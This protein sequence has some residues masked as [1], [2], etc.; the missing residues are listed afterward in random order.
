MPTELRCYPKLKPSWL[1]GRWVVT[2]QRILLFSFQSP[3]PEWPET[4]CPVGQTEMRYFAGRSLGMDNRQLLCRTMLSDQGNAFSRGRGGEAPTSQ[5]PWC[6]SWWWDDE[7]Y[8]RCSQHQWLL[9]ER[10]RHWTGQCLRHTLAPLGD[11][12]TNTDQTN[13]WRNVDYVVWVFVLTDL[14]VFPW[15]AQLVFS[16]IHVH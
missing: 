16:L 15:Y 14:F 10:S 8:P 5:S 12:N 11:L 7:F 13:D 1:N 2:I 9:E 6:H 4:F 3:P